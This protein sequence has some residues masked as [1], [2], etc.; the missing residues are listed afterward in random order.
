MV[1]GTLTPRVAPTH[2]DPD[3]HLLLRGAPRAQLAWLRARGLPD[4]TLLALHNACQ[5]R[6]FFCAGPGTSE[7][8]RGEISSLAAALAHLAARPDG[9]TRLLVGGNEPTAHPEF[10]AVLQAIRPSGFSS[11]ELMTSGATLRQRLAACLSAGLAEV[12]VPLYSA[13][14]ALHDKIVGAPSFHT[15]VA[16]L[17]AAHAA[18]VRVRV[19]TLLWRETVDG[20]GRLAT[21][22]STRWACRLG[23]A[24]PRDKDRFDFSASVPD[25][26]TAAHAVAALPPELRPLG[27]LT[28]AC[29]P[30][31]T[32]TPPLLAEL[33][34]RSQRRTFGAAC[35]A[36]ALRPDC[37]GAVVAWRDRVSPP[38]DPRGPPV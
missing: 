27:L 34:F 28:P 22:V 10:D 38:G 29:L 7:V 6:C 19:H 16:G 9:V 14:A 21:L 11:F 37:S 12:V 31:F 15:V 8:A 5:Q 17:D 4:A 32:A 20:L 25:F 30:T 1:T 35:T 2:E 33:Y 18:G 36:C 24:L 23:V 13:E 3:L 26:L